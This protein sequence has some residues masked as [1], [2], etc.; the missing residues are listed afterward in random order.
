MN[1]EDEDI[2][3]IEILEPVSNIPP[4]PPSRKL[5]PSEKVNYVSNPVL[6]KAYVDWYKELL[7]AEVAGIEEPEM[8]RFIAESVMKICTRLSYRPN[9]QNY[10]FRDEMV[11]DAIENCIRTIKKFNPAKSTNPFSYITTIAFNAFLRRIAIEKKQT[12]IKG[13]MIEEMPIDELVDV[14]DGD[15]DTMQ[16]H[17]QFLNYLKEHSY[18]VGT[19]ITSR[20]KKRPQLHEDTSVFETLFDDEI[21]KEDQSE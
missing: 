10:S 7:D 15:D 12:Y 19:K 11:A 2:G 4:T 20:K 3:L 9:F 8:P 17:S 21:E 1:E 16:Q 14:Q 6:Y 5:K 13:K 18:I